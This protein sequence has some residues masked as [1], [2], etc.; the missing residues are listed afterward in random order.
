MKRSNKKGFTIVE[1]VI[2]IAI[3]AILAAVLIPTFASLIQKAN[4]SADIQACRQMNT[5]LAVNEVTADKTIVEVYEALKAGGMDAEDYKPLSSN[6]YYFWDAKL[7]RVLYTNDSYEVIYP[8]EYKNVKSTDAD[9]QWYSLTTEIKGDSNY[10]KTEAEGI[11]TITVNSG[12][13]LYQAVKDLERSGEIN[14]K[15]T[16][17]GMTTHFE[18]S[19]N[20]NTVINITSDIDMM[21][22]SL[23]I[24][25]VMSNVKLTIN[26][27]GH[28]IKGVSN[29]DSGVVDAA[30]NDDNEKRDYY[31]SLIKYVDENATVEFNNIKFDNIVT[32]RKDVG[33]SGILIGKTKGTKTNVTFDGVVITNST[34]YGKNKLGAFIGAQYSGGTKVTVKGNTKLEN[35]KIISTEG[36]SGILF[37]STS[38]GGVNKAGIF[39][40]KALMSD[41]DNFIKNCSVVCE[42]SKMYDATF[43]EGLNQ[44][45]DGKVVEKDKNNGYR[46]TT[47]Y[48]GF[49]GAAK[50][51]VKFTM[52]GTEYTATNFNAINTY[53]Q[54]VAAGWVYDFTTNQAV[55]ANGN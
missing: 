11:T 45:Y 43:S 22:A 29:L 42:S 18:N 19:I 14:L 39:I 26:G 13:Q 8:D 37:G 52:N 6:T 17:E 2:V 21:G 41:F 30:L 33:S 48:L 15:T 4:T 35:V 7:N 44:T 38:D 23:S 20:K 34:L 25:A 27:N 3:I 36:E 46:P 24:G 1:L 49:A 16:G 12:G 31:A 50:D 40:D 55:T 5:Y 9:H 28:T 32:G 51:T 54:A 47:A 53:D 10:S